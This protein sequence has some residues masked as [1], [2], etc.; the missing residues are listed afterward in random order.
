MFG[1]DRDDGSSSSRSS[2]GGNSATGRPAGAAGAAGASDPWP[3]TGFRDRLRGSAFHHHPKSSDQVIQQ[4]RDE[5]DKQRQ[6][7]FDRTPHQWDPPSKSP[8]Q[9][10]FPFGDGS[11]RTVFGSDR[12]SI[13]HHFHEDIPSWLHDDGIFR[14]QRWPSNGSGR[15]AGSNSSTGSNPEPVSIHPSIHPSI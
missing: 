2:S 12:T 13:P 4:L 9:G 6:M 15:S 5:L 8:R 11:R 1:E 7:F 14:R 3:P 10:A